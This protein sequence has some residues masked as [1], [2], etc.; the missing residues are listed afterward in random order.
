MFQKKYI[1]TPFFKLIFNWIFTNFSFLQFYCWDFLDVK[2]G[3]K[4]FF[5][6]K[7]HIL[8]WVYHFF[9]ISFLSSRFIENNDWKYDAEFVKRTISP[10]YIFSFLF[11]GLRF[12]YNKFE[13]TIDNRSVASIGCWFLI[14]FN[15]F[16]EFFLIY[17][18][19]SICRLV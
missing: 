4:I 11:F 2:L 14:H 15:S 8:Y 6:L 12:Y 7:F 10:I 3:D 1:F 18:Y 16:H 9:H 17:I 5:I 13:K 19:I